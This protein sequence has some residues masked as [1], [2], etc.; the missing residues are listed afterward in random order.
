M[1]IVISQAINQ[2]PAVGSICVTSCSVAMQYM[3]TSSD[4]TLPTHSICSGSFGDLWL[5]TDKYTSEDLL[6]AAIY[7]RMYVVAT[8]HA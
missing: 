5:S 3:Y 6:R 1:L 4:N 2:R 8:F 7:I